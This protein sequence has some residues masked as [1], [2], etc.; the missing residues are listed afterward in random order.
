VTHYGLNPSFCTWTSRL[1]LFADAIRRGRAFELFYDDGNIVLKAVPEIGLD[2]WP[3][4]APPGN[5]NGVRVFGDMDGRMGE[6]NIRGNPSLKV[7]AN[8]NGATLLWKGG[9]PQTAPIVR[10]HSGADVLKGFAAT[11][12]A[13]LG[14]FKPAVL[15]TLDWQLTNKRTD[16]SKPRVLPADPLQ[17]TDRG[18]AVELQAEA[19]NLLGAALWWCAP[20]RYELSVVE[21]ERRLEEMLGAIK[22]TT[23]RP[24]VIEYGNELWHD[25]FPVHGW[26]ESLAAP[27][28]TWHEIAG[29]EIARLKRVA[30]RVFGAPGPLGARP[31]YLFVGGQL[32]VP[33]HLDRILSRLAGVGVTPDCA[34]PAL[35]VTPLKASMEEWEATGAVPMQEEL[36]A[37][38][39]ARL[40]EIAQI[41]PLGPLEMH[42]DIR[43]RYGVP[44]FA[45][46]EAGQSM[47]ADS[48]PWR[49]AAIAAQRTEWMGDLYREIRRVAEAAGVDLLNWYSACTSQTP[50]DP[51]V[52]VFG[53]LEGVSDPLLPKAR[54]AMGGAA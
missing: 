5:W 21:Y 22:S 1:P 23:K 20:P 47:I 51:R 4:T 32:T 15:R 40:K 6:I 52:D 8:A 43:S 30:D 37:S 53:L 36:R 54:A 46:Y 42:D 18:M 3:V 11:S 14:Q 27:G 12:L 44:Y 24:P 28:H 25:K 35:Y 39:F 19:A 50:T 49:A 9:G 34:G 29:D 2:G 7:R 41:V 33:S 16:W 10:A 45:C 48:A 26:L 17:G 13:A 38:C 31:Y